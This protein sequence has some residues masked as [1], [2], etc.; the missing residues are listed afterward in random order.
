DQ[1]VAAADSASVGDAARPPI[2][3]QRSRTG[4]DRYLAAFEQGLQ[5][6]GEAIDHRLLARLR[7]CE[8]QRGV[9]S[10]NPEL[11]GGAYGAQHL[12][13]LQQFL[14]GD[15]AAMQAGTPDALLLDHGDVHPRAG[16]V[17]G[18]GVSARATTEYDEVEVVRHLVGSSRR[19]PPRRSSLSS[20][21]EDDL[22]ANASRINKA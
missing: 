20:I 18:R 2:A 8:L 7:G 12:G 16:A 19:D 21:H 4:D 11:G 13:G 22:E 5:P 14:G 6:R 9:G 3:R 10:Q 1:R 17:E 15:T